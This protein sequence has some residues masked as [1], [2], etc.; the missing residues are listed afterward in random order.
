VIDIGANY[1]VYTLSIA[2]TVGLQGRVWAFEPSSRTAKFLAESIAVNQFSQVVLEQSALSSESGVGKLSMQSNSELNAL[3]RDESS[4]SPSETI[5]LLTLD[6][7][8][9]KYDW[10]SIDFIKIDA[11]GEEANILRG[12]SRF[13]AE[14][15]PL[16]QYEI[17]AGSDLNLDLV[18]L[19]ADLGYESYRLVPGLD[20]LVPFTTQSPPDGYLLNLF[21]C[22]P[23]RA[24]QLAAA[25]F[26]ISSQY[27]YSKSVSERFE[28]VLQT[29]KTET[30]F[31]CRHTL[32]KLPYGDYLQE[33]W[34]ESAS[35]DSSLQVL[36]ALSL[37]TL[38]QMSQSAVERFDALDA[39]LSLLLTVCE[40]E[41]THLRLASL[42]RVA[43]EYGAR[44][45][46][47]MALQQLSNNIVVTKQVD[48][49]EPFL[50]PSE[51][52]D[53]LPIGDEAGNWVLAAVFEELE[54]L[55]AFSSYYSGPSAWNRL[56]DI[57]SLGFQ[58]DEMQRRL[59][60]SKQRFKNRERANLAAA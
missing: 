1:G 59:Q 4:N 32:M 20:L 52:F 46:A 19:F 22:K 44:S 11:E 5:T 45:Y 40:K 48:P 38:S 47:V 10:Q 29:V 31:D 14:Q 53:T 37:Y 42:A 27:L 60:L 12:G 18:N 24:Q 25:G 8:L 3:V 58:S 43:R 49:S 7:C 26:L 15:S 21:C 57:R 17:K 35:S 39:S 23:D 30:M 50:V 34:S 51:R 16:V 28:A 13:F 41:A 55:Y 54:K 9:E 56:E 36:E 33:M 2:K 6:D